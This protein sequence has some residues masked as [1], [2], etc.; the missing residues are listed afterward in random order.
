MADLDAL[1]GSVEE[2]VGYH[3][4]GARG[5]TGVEELDAPVVC[6]AFPLQVTLARRGSKLP[7]ILK[8]LTDVSHH[9]FV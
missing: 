6:R 8:G 4:G 5:V 1:M 3:P 2:E 7:S 9:D